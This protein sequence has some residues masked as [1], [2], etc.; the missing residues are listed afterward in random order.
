M[1]ILLKR[2][3]VAMITLANFSI[4][5]T[6]HA[7]DAASDYP[8]R[9]VRMLLPN[10]AGSSNDMLGRILSAKLGEAL[11]QQVYVENQA[12]ASGLI[13]MEMAKNSAPDGYTIVSA[14][15][16]GMSIAP[17]LHK[18]LPY[19]PLNDFQFISLYAVLPNLLVVTP[20]LPVKTVQDLI[21]YV[22]ARPGQINMASAGPGSQSHLAGVLLQIMGN[23]SSVHVPYK[24]GGASVVSVMTGETQWTIT[25]ASSVIGH[26]RSGKL[27]A[28][29]HSL[30]Q[31][32]PLLVDIPTVGESIAGFSYSAWNG[33]V[34]SKA[35]PAPVVEK[36]RTALL[37]TL[38]LQEVKES[39]N[40]QGAE[41]V[42]NTAEDFR[43]LV[44]AEIENT[45]RVVKASGLKVVE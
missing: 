11:G 19:D 29:A 42:T 4:S 36:I 8:K 15:P 39:L 31:R 40:K 32:S 44:R 24:G 34:V 13:G 37:K 16:A 14:S 23:F 25:P 9:S 6:A 17:N 38:S 28:V 30:P 2:Y 35:T 22:K 18:Q 26:V 45:A 43:N 20:S 21:E 7:A 41:I 12:G 33:I 10:A 27:R 5:A 3:M 1:R